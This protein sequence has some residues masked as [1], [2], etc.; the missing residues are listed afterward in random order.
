M[1]VPTGD[2]GNNGIIITTGT[3]AT[4][5]TGSSGTDTVTVHAA[6]LAQDTLLTLA[7]ARLRSK[8]STGLVGDLNAQTLTGALT[9]TTGDAGNN[10]IIITTGTSGDLDRP[11]RPAPTP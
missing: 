2:A 1:T 8:W 7:R 6:A 9:V 4:S 10:G 5:I 11:G 3:A